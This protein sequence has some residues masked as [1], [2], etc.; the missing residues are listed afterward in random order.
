[1]CG[2]RLQAACAQGLLDL[3]KAFDSVPHHILI[4]EAKLLGYPLRILRLSL[5]V[6]VMPRTLRVGLVFSLTLV[7]R[8]GITAG[9]G[10]A[11]TEMRL[12]MIHV[13][14]A[15]RKEYTFVVPTLY[16]DDLSAEVTA[17][18]KAV[19]EMLVGFML[20]VC[21]MIEELGMEVS[22]DKSV[23]TA[24][25]S[26]L[27]RG[28]A[29]A[30]SDFGITYVQRAKSLGAGLGGGV[31]RNTTVQAKRR[32]ALA[33]RISSFRRLRMLQV[34]TAKLLR[35]G[36]NGGVTYDAAITGVPPSTLLQF[37]RTCATIQAPV[38]GCSGQDI[39]LALMVAD[40]SAT[41]MADPAFGA[42]MV[43]IGTWSTAIWEKWLP[44]A[45][46]EGSVAEAKCK[47]VKAPRPW[48]VATGPASVFVLTAARLE[49]TV[50][51]ATAVTTDD[52]TLLT[53]HLDPPA[54]VKA[55]CRLSVQRWR[56]RNVQRKFPTLCSGNLGVGAEMT[57]IWSLLRSREQSNRWNYQFR[58]A[59]KS[60]LA[61]R[62]YTQSRCFAAG[63][64]T[65]K[66]CLVC[67]HHL[68]A[69]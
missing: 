4:R 68:M 46:L 41:G 44:L 9:S 49:W 59:L 24:C 28:I 48:A 13:V 2:W 10:T 32:R 3:V 35:T 65:H 42:H 69:K 25:D 15:A 51:G 26:E 50:H 7:A 37:R 21:R 5:Q 16:V 33:D 14:D 67:L 27:G 61:G 12:L 8:R 22:R 20:M 38:S 52:G 36:G 56:W 55:E 57:G 45:I 53:L 64:A 62:Q 40:G 63:F 23:C 17:S 66:A 19:H 1:M 39:D 58:G 60:A 54:V 34:D 11:T 18:R 30:L 29:V 47:A 31:R 6:Y 43:P